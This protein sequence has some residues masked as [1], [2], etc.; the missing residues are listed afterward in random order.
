MRQE[1]AKG[2]VWKTIPDPRMEA[3][4]LAR[5]IGRRIA[6]FRKAKGWSRVELARALGVRRD[7]LSRWER[8]QALPPLEMLRPLG[9]KLGVS[10]DELINGEPPRAMSLDRKDKELLIRHV[11]A[12]RKL[13]L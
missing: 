7:R 1:T 12:M 4:D 5:E 3:E 13:L 10:I 2:V 9:I 11:V 6:R 8:G